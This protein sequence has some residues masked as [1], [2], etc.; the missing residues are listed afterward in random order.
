MNL[1]NLLM[2]SMTSSSSVDSLSKKTGLK[3]ITI[4]TILSYALPLLTKF[5]TANAAKADGAQSLLGA[6]TQHKSTK[7]VA[8]Q[9]STADANDGQ[10]IIG[11]IFG[12]QADS[13]VGQI[14]KQS[15]ASAADV[16]KIL[17]LIAPAV[18]SSLSAATTQTQQAQ[19]ANAGF[20]L[21]SLL[22]MFG[23]ANNTNDVMNAFT[24]SDANKNDGVNGAQLL[25]SLLGLMK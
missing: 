16:S 22:G 23:G 8:D 1:L 12:N 15:G 5:M 14:A 19:Q 25:T 10:K 20:D 7:S 17:A 3:G 24:Q 11:H 4:L 9:I 6:L 13:A 21:G 18:L 2:G